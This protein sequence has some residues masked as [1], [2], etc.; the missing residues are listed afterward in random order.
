MKYPTLCL[1]Y[2][3]PTSTQY[4]KFDLNPT[5]LR[6]YLCGTDQSYSFSFNMSV[7]PQDVVLPRGSTILVTGANGYISSHVI[8]QFLK[9]GY[10][11]QGTVRNVEKSA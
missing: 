9:Y 6:L 8:N 10:K 1:F 4:V 11:A 2:I 7:L 5:L 3:V